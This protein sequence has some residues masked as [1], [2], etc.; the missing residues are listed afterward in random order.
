MKPKGPHLV[1]RPAPESPPTPPSPPW[2]DDCWRVR[3]AGVQ[4]T[5]I[6]SLLSEEAV[7]KSFTD[8]LFKL[9][10]LMDEQFS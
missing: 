8:F 10:T 6:Q 2:G 1:D 5:S 7:Q 9:S 4:K 3:A